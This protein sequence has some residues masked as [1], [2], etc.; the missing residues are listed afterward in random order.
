MLEGVDAVDWPRLTY[1]HGSAANVP[2]M[3]RDLASTDRS[4]AEA[5][6][7]AVLDALF[8]QGEVYPATVPAIRFLVELAQHASHQRAEI[9]QTIGRGVDPDHAYGRAVRKVRAAVQEHA[10]VLR[11]LLTDPDPAV[12]AAAAYAVAH[13]D[14]AAAALGERWAAEQAPEVRASLL[15]ALHRVAPERVRDLLPAAT[16]DGPYPVR[17][18]AVLAL[19]RGGDQLPE[20]AIEAAAEAL[21]AGAEI[22]EAWWASLSIVD[23]LVEHLD[24]PLLADPLGRLLA[25]TPDAEARQRLVAAA[26]DDDLC[27]RSRSVPHRFV[28]LLGAA[29]AD[30]DAEVRHAAVYSLRKAGAAAGRYA[31]ELARVAEDFPRVASE[32]YS[33]AG[34]AVEILALLGDPRWLPAVSAAWE[35]GHRTRPWLPHEPP[36]SPAVLAAARRRL[37]ELATAQTGEASGAAVAFLADLLGWWGRAAA[38]AEPELPAVAHHAPHEVARALANIGTTN[39]SV[40]SH[41]RGPALAHDVDCAVGY[42][43][44]T[45]DASPLVDALTWHLD[46]GVTP[47]QPMPHRLLERA[48]EAGMALGALVPRLRG[49]LVRRDT[50]PLTADPLQVSAARLIWEATG[51]AVDLLPTVLGGLSD[52]ICASAAVELADRIAHPPLIPALRLLLSQPAGPAAAR[53]L[54]RL[55]EPV[56]MLVPALVN[57]VEEGEREAVSVLVEMGA[58]AAVPDLVRLAERDEPIDVHGYAVDFVWNDERLQEELRAAL[59]ILRSE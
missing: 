59:A 42:W 36:C 30:P 50:R 16:V 32:R 41:L 22:H 5:G 3:L 18:A 7:Q 33:P 24:V 26:M 37:A 19:L 57:A 20:S 39:R 28:P 29:L 17:L 25:T 10:G 27:R 34:A 55:G 40:A 4:T 14:G 38:E 2:D 8:H 51:S 47:G 9:V 12:R 45:G 52:S 6:L 35:A 1:A 49:Y 11:A 46:R 43:R 31:D 54:W 23:E 56:D 13:C 44:V 21:A 48:T 15:L 58:V 53:A